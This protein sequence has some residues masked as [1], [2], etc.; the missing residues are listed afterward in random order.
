MTIRNQDAFPVPSIE[1]LRRPLTDDERRE[2]RGD[3]AGAVSKEDLEELDRILQTGDA[4]SRA[5][6]EACVHALIFRAMSDRMLDPRNGYV[7][8][9]DHGISEAVDCFNSIV[10]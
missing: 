4:E 7:T 2:I 1:S 9:F 8:Q 5:L 10:R 3:R 6:A